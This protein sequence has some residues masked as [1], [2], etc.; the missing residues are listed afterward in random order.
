MKIAI[1]GALGTIGR[2]LVELLDSLGHRVVGIDQYHQPLREDDATPFY[3]ADISSYR[4]LRDALGSVQNRPEIV[5]NLA[6]EF[7]RRNGEEFSEQCWSTNCLGLRNVLRIQQEMGFLLVHFSSSEIYGNAS[8]TLGELYTETT[9]VWPQNDYAI[10]KLANEM[11]I[12]N[13]RAQCGN[14][15]MTIRL[16]NAYGPGEYYTPYRSVVALFCY[17]LLHGLPIVVYEGYR[18]P[19]MF[20]GDLLDTLSR[21]PERFADG[22]IV[23]IGGSEIREVREVVDII[24]GEGVG[25]TEMIRYVPVEEHNVRDKIPSTDLARELLDHDPVTTIEDGIPKTLGWFRGG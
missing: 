1:I 13:A 4:Q 17:R 24:M 21:I 20:L 2:P 11:Q 5:F 19:F 7:G 18:R 22:A 9:P 10:S 25:S 23:N 14:Q 15:I 3:R 12:R 8:G 16:F 6:A